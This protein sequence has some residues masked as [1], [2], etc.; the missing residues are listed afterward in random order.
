MVVGAL[1]VCSVGT[2]MR[3]TQRLRITLPDDLADA[4]RAKVASGEYATESDVIREAL[5][6]LF[7]RDRVVETW[8]R[9]RVAES[10]DALKA[11]PSRGVDVATVKGHLAG[12]R[13]RGS[14]KK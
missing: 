13:K 10:Y 11:D 7:A 12:A 3:S 8:L 5:G 4:L 6:L 14:A 9:E 1:R 2:A